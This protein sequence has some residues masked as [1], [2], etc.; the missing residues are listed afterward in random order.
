MTSRPTTFLEKAGTQTKLALRVAQRYGC[1]ME[2]VLP[3]D[4]RLSLMSVGEFYMRAASYRI[5]SYNNLGRNLG[6]WRAWLA[7][8]G[9][10]LTR[11]NVDRTWDRA[12]L[13]RG[14]LEVYRPRTTRGGHAVCLVGYTP[15]YF[16]VRNSWGTSWGDRGFGYAFNAYAEQAFT[17]AYGAIL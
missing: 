10:I 15:D 14:R 5:R 16:I 11:L 8:Q 3:M 17:E 9:P 12:A 13:T 1:V 6:R 7:N 4:G 2:S